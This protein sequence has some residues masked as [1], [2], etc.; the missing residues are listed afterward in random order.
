[1]FESLLFFLNRE[2]AKALLFKRNINAMNHYTPNAADSLIRVLA[3]Q[4]TA[5]AEA[6]NS[7][8]SCSSSSASLRILSSP[9]HQCLIATTTKSRGKHALR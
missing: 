5:T 2:L 3:L 1:M 6:D 7:V 8:R 9:M 4:A